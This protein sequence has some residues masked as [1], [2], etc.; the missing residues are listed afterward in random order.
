MGHEP[1]HERDNS[2]VQKHGGHEYKG[3]RKAFEPVDVAL[4]KNLDDGPLDPAVGR[5]NHDGVAPEVGY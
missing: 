1:P 4:T 5:K 2:Q 3:K